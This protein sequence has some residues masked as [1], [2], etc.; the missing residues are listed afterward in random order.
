VVFLHPIQERTP[1]EAEKLR[2]SCAVPSIHIER[3]PDQRTLDSGE[4]NACCG[5]G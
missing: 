1:R 4:I 2:R 5:D 3:K